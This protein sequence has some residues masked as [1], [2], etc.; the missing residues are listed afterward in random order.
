MDDHHLVISQKNH[1]KNIF[2]SN[3]EEVSIIIIFLKTAS[4][5]QIVHKLPH[6]F[7]KLLQQAEIFYDIS[8]PHV[9][10]T[11]RCVSQSVSSWW[12]IRSKVGRVWEKSL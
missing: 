2:E 10:H 11:P 3:S 4:R 8:K 7:L 5:Q 12:D 1:P 6:I 9:Q